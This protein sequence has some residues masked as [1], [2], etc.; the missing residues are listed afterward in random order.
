MFLNDVCQSG[1]H[2][3]QVVMSLMFWRP[4]ATLMCNMVCVEHNV[5]MSIASPAISFALICLLL[6]HFHDQLVMV[7]INYCDY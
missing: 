4:L 3:C 2:L 7:I 6:I 5:I 1:H